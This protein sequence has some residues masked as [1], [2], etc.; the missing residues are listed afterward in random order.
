LSTS[1]PDPIRSDPTRPDPTH[2]FS[3]ALYTC[4]AMMRNFPT[5]RRTWQRNPTASTL[6]TL[7][8]TAAP[9][10]DGPLLNVS[11]T[12]LSLYLSQRFPQRVFKTNHAITL[13]DWTVWIGS[14]YAGRSRRARER[15]VDD[16]RRLPRQRSRW[17]ATPAVIPGA[18]ILMCTVGGGGA[19]AAGPA[20]T[21][22]L[23]CGR[24]G[25]YSRTFL[26][27]TRYVIFARHVI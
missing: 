24:S 4:L 12:V 14:G 18:W 3:D 17:R 23:Y 27:F 22:C 6:A 9:R 2:R 16:R 1:R 8:L 19:V 7:R 25:E 15:T 11:S 20:C 5:T 21:V 26:I 13:V 10:L